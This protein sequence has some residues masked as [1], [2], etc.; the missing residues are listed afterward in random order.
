M[1][2]DHLYISQIQLQTLFNKKSVVP[3]YN[4]ENIFP[5]SLIK[6]ILGDRCEQNVIE[7]EEHMQLYSGLMTQ[8]CS[9]EVR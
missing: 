7:A 8:R 9:K 1:A 2:L 6:L 4:I 3:Q 5:N